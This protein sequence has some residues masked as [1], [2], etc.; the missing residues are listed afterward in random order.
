[1]SDAN[2][3]AA[4]VRDS[5]AALETRL[6]ADP[7]SVVSTVIERR[8]AVGELR[9][10][11]RSTDVTVHDPE[12]LAPETVG[13]LVDALVDAFE[14]A[15]AVQ[16]GSRAT[17]LFNVTTHARDLQTDVLATLARLLDVSADGAPPM[18]RVDG[19]SRPPALAGEADG[20]RRLEALAAAGASALSAPPSH[21]AVKP[22]ISLLGAVSV[23]DPAAVG[24]REDV[25]SVA[26][27]LAGGFR[28]TDATNVRLPI[29]RALHAVCEH[30]HPGVPARPDLVNVVDTAR[31]ADD[32]VVRAGG[33]ALATT[34]E[35]RPGS[36]ATQTA[37]GTVTVEDGDVA[38]FLDAVVA[39]VDASG[40]P[41]RYA[42]L[43]EAIDSGV[44]ASVDERSFQ[45]L[46]DVVAADEELVDIGGPV[47]IPVD[48]FEELREQAVAAIDHLVDADCVPSSTTVDAAEVVGA[49]AARDRGHETYARA[50]ARLAEADLVEPDPQRLAA[51]V[52]SLTDDTHLRLLS[53]TALRRLVDADLAA[54]RDV[55]R[56]RD[57]LVEAIA[58]ERSHW[59]AEALG[60]L[61]ADFPAVDVSD[62]LPVA[63][64]VADVRA[65][66]GSKSVLAAKTLTVL[67]DAGVRTEAID[68]SLRTL[69]RAA[70]APEMGDTGAVRSLL[71]TLADEGLAP[72]LPDAV[73]RQYA[74]LVRKDPGL[75]PDDGL[76]A[77]EASA[78]EVTGTTEGLEEVANAAAAVVPRASADACRHAAAIVVACMPPAADGVDLSG[79]VE[80]LAAAVPALGPSARNHQYELL[81]DLLEAGASGVD[82]I[83]VSAVVRDVRERT[84][85]DDTAVDL[86]AVLVAR[87]ASEVSGSRL[88]STLWFA[89]EEVTGGADQAVEALVELARQDA[90]PAARVAKGFTAAVRAD[91][92]RPA[93]GIVRHRALGGLGVLATT[94]ELSTAPSALR[95]TLVATFLEHGRDSMAGVL[96][97]LVESNAFPPADLAARLAHRAPATRALTAPSWLDSPTPGTLAL[98]ETA[99]ARD[100]DA[101][102]RYA[103]ALRR[104]LRGDALDPSERVTVIRILQRLTATASN[105]RTA[106]PI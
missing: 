11:V 64:L 23:L 98:L 35:G 43:V 15:H 94:G 52:R 62:P 4:D 36:D 81:V 40:P 12:P 37:T 1:M 55:I 7:G 69:R 96:E 85:A 25:A 87:Q 76:R 57:R 75:T 2:D 78:S 66:S 29:L 70:R 31:A 34:L 61:A 97:T 27:T 74:F 77:I 9:S 73:R 14:H 51:A 49:L 71:E 38:A 99:T 102:Q 56:L 20:R 13:S 44:V 22:A 3:R 41:L 83:P 21:D 68:V 106:T 53:T 32:H 24:S 91:D 72:T 92:R 60:E 16:T 5:V 42:A 46:V 93:S 10:L 30:H 84:I 86:L 6:R 89:L 47:P 103:P 79:V 95:T 19:G 59:A 58:T 50:L 48:S 104:L 105:P 17:A 18:P 65:V 8:E 45:R 80:S 90:V 54:R 39:G 33:L 100:P 28:A 67:V 26:P 101:F 88:E 82:A 63:S